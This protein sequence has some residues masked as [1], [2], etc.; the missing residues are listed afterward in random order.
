MLMIQGFAGDKTAQQ[1]GLFI[2]LNTTEAFLQAVLDTSVFLTLHHADAKALVLGLLNVEVTVEPMTYTLDELDAAYKKAF[3]DRKVAKIKAKSCVVPPSPEGSVMALDAI[4]ARLDV[5]RGELDALLTATGGSQARRQA[6]ERRLADLGPLEMPLDPAAV[7]TLPARIADLEERLAIMEAEV[8]P[9][10][11]PVTAPVTRPAKT[12]EGVS[13][14]ELEARIKALSTFTP[15]KGCVL[16]PRVPC[17]THKL[18]FV[19]RGKDLQAT[20]DEDVTPTAPKPSVSVTVN[21]LTAVRKELEA[22]KTQQSTLVHILEENE[23]RASQRQTL[24]AELASLPDTSAEEAKIADLRNRIAVGEGKRKDA[25]AHQRATQVHE[26]GLETQQGLQA[27]VDRLEALCDILGPS[28]ARV[29][30]LADALGPF[31]QAV[32]SYTTPFGWT[33]SFHVEPWGVIVND[34]P[35]ET[36]SRSEQY[37]IGLAIQLSIAA[38]SGLSFAVVD[39]LDMLDALNRDTV[40]RML[41]AAPLEQILILGTRE[42]SSPLP[43]IQDMLAYRIGTNEN[44]RSVI[45]EQSRG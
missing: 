15:T 31:E 36:Y 26:Q 7:E 19:N 44:G 35:V 27:E 29:Q 22:L 20:L 3:E 13:R 37:R 1:A 40:G 43:K 5:L 45:L 23:G 24:E 32:N 28:G 16:D 17:N 38:L 18:K 39:E 21:P 14:S 12:L 4:N 42:P 41:M 30:A 11:E 34:R 25:E 2:K 9:E 33:V 8:V 6:I 10:A